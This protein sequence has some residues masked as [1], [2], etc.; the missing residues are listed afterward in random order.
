[1]RLNFPSYEY[2]YF[3]MF[4]IARLSKCFVCVCSKLFILKE[5]ARRKAMMLVKQTVLRQQ[6]LAERSTQE[7][8]FTHINKKSHLYRRALF[9][10]NFDRMLREEEYRALRIPQRKAKMGV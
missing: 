6:A 10:E 7:N 4:F 9:H 1:M 2:R 5:Q 3:Y 8:T